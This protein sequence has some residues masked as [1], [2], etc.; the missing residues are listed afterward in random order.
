MTRE[1]A[2]Q[3]RCLQAV[4]QEAA[5]RKPFGPLD[6][7]QGTADLVGDLAQLGLVFLKVLDLPRDAAQAPAAQGAEPKIEQVLDDPGRSVVQ[8]G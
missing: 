6:Q 2:V 5:A 7:G 3:T 8:G 1:I 4:Q